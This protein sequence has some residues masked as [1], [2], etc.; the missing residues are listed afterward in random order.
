[1]LADDD[2]ATAAPA[3]TTRRSAA[4]GTRALLRRRRQSPRRRL[5]RLRPRLH[6]LRV[7]DVRACADAESSDD[8]T[9]AESAIGRRA[10]P[11]VASQATGDA[12]DLPSDKVRSLDSA[13][14]P[15]REQR[16]PR[17]ALVRRCARQ[18]D[19][20]PPRRPRR[21]QHPRPHHQPPRP[22][23]Q[24]PIPRPSTPP[25]CKDRGRL[26]RARRRGPVQTKM[27]GRASNHPNR[28]AEEPISRAHHLD[29]ALRYFQGLDMS[30]KEKITS[31]QPDQ[32]H[33]LKR[34]F[35][36]RPDSRRRPRT[37]LR[38]RGP[39]KARSESAGALAH[40]PHGLP[41]YAQKQAGPVPAPGALVRIGFQGNDPRTDINRAMAS[42]YYNSCTCLKRAAPRG[43]PLRAANQGVYQC[44]SASSGTEV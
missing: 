1:M 16:Q 23:H 20:P 37:R 22:P 27:P 28:A 24:P 19:R 3:T 18:Q 5:R 12:P 39:A 9:D 42:L 17:P 36:R 43:R 26:P 35:K 21:R 6:A 10:P 4:R 29:E 2:D 44:G 13:P 14:P 33:V 32:R 40:D 7:Y 11:P 30:H 41:D 8:E 31:T 38:L 34:I 15:K 25:F